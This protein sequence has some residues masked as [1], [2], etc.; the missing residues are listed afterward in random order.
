MLAPAASCSLSIVYSP[1]LGGNEQASLLVNDN[2]AGG[3]SAAG[4]M[5]PGFVSA[6]AVTLAPGGVTFPGTTEGASSAPVTLTVTNSGTAALHLQSNAIVLTGSNAADFNQTNTCNGATVAAQSSCTISVTFQPSAV[7][8]R[9]AEVQIS[10]DAPG[11][12]Q[13]VSLSGN[14][15]AA[16]LPAVT[17]TSASLNFPT[18][19]EGASSAPQAMTVTNSGLAALR[20]STNGI[21]LAGTNPGDFSETDTCNG[22]V[23]AP[24]ATCSITVIFQPTATGM[25][26]AQVLISDNA[27]NSPQAVSM[28]GVGALPSPPATA[29]VTLMPTSLNFTNTDEGMVSAP[30]S[31]TVTNV[32]GAAL[33]IPSN[34]ITFTGTNPGDFTETD[35]CS[36]SAVAI[37][38]SCTI[39]VVFQPTAKGSRT[40][41][42]QISDDAPGAPQTLSV[43]GIGV[44]PPFLLGTSGSSGMSQTVTAGMTAQYDLQLIPVN[45]FTGAVSLTCAGVPL[46]AT[47]TVPS[48]LTIGGTT[49]VPFIVTVTT[50]A[51]SL[52]PTFQGSP[53]K[54]ASREWMSL[55]VWFGFLVGFLFLLLLLSRKGPAPPPAARC[56]VP[57]TAAIA[58]LLTL[59]ACLVSCAG[60]ASIAPASLST[61]TP[62]GSS[63]I[64]VTAMQ[65]SSVTATQISN[66]T[67]IVQ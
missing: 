13:F 18:T 37:G 48:T 60:T 21:S 19:M 53:A 29:A 3:S 41:Q 43:S 7:G 20:I 30:M 27:V 24:Q 51:R 63:T 32:G 17:L 65:Q 11:S 23:V 14:G 22:S 1:S 55:G 50:T 33:N 57:K 38:T 44:V 62:S 61:G 28:S 66:L 26:A 5:G 42:V 15:A 16:P 54:P 4:L 64:T 58:S 47:C 6:S 46:N 10:D 67:L 25:R 45:G 40:A 56:N 49:A 31:I 12:P 59:S 34:G 52:L 9:T 8:A 35:T 2:V 36:N 39:I